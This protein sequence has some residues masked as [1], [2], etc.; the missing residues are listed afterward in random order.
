MKKIL[1][2]VGILSLLAGAYFTFSAVN[3]YSPVVATAEAAGKPVYNGTLYVAGMGGHFSVADVTIDPNNEAA[4]IKVNS[5]DML[6]IGGASHP[7][8]DARIDDKDRNTMYWSTYK[9]DNWK[10]DPESKDA[11]AIGNL[12]VG[13]SNLKTGE[14][15]ADV[16]FPAP[17]RAG[18]TGAN[19]CASGQSA[20]SYIPISMANEGYIDVFDKNTMALK[21]RIFFD[22]LGIK[23]GETT[24]AHGIN[25]PDMTKFLLT[26]NDTP[27]GFT[28]WTGNTKLIYLDMAALEQGKIKKIAEA[29]ITGKPK[30]AE[31][32]TITF[33]QY[34][35]AD[36]KYLL[37]SGADRGYLIDAETL[38]VLDEITPLPGENHDILPTPDGKYAVMTLREK[39]KD[40][41]GNDS[42]D[43]TLLLYDIEARK[44]VGSSASVC[45]ACH[46]GEGIGKAILCGL[47]GN[48]KM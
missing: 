45:F 13:K 22:D 30:D 8:H 39:A 46:K 9:L 34:F 14:V 2:T 16:A 29:M 27:E 21:H 19:Y 3:S 44:T 28:K 25:T 1:S 33:R 32:G 38:K 26:V 24:F 17:E 47:D 23:A 18:W 4:P 31:G 12:H 10:D 5:V 36:G 35:T 40:F 48:W 42:V 6:D 37:Q 41:E 43:G 15:V 11:K 20:T 7:T